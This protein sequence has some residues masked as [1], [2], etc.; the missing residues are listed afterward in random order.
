MSCSK[1]GRCRRCRARGY[2]CSW[3]SRL[4]CAFCSHKHTS[5]WRHIWLPEQMYLVRRQLK[6]I[7]SYK[8]QDS[9]IVPSYANCT[10]G[11]TLPNEYWYDTDTAQNIRDDFC[12]EVELR[13]LKRVRKSAEG[14]TADWNSTTKSSLVLS[15]FLIS[16]ITMARS[17]VTTRTAI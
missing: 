2:S 8:A 11:S 17:N 3:S 5:G 9:I 10:S 4:Q 15:N 14:M 13:Y 12:L 16:N 7:R 6:F 1:H